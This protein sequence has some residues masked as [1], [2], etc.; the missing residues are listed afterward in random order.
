[1]TSPKSELGP[2]G[3]RLCFDGRGFERLFMPYPG[4]DD[5]EPESDGM[6]GKEN[7][8]SHEEQKPDPT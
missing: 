7:D 4:M 2:Y 8:R 3:D 1:M 5:E 6:D